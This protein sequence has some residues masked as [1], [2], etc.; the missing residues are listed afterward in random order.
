MRI[1]HKGVSGEIEILY[2]RGMA[3]ILLGGDVEVG[4]V[5]EGCLL[6]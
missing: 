6:V 3:T 4:E 5:R 2:K 1:E